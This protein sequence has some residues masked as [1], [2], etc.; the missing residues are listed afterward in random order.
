MKNHLFSSLLFSLILFVHSASYAQQQLEIDVNQTGIISADIETILDNVVV[1]VRNL[2]PGPV[3]A[4]FVA[5]L[6]GTDVQG[7]SIRVDNFLTDLQEVV[8]TPGG[9]LFTI[10]RLIEDY[11]NSSLEEYNIAPAMLRDELSQTRRLPEGSYQL[12]V[13]ALSYPFGELISEPLLQSC[14]QFE[15]QYLDPPY[16]TSPD[17][18]SLVVDNPLDE[19]IVFWTMPQARMGTTYL[20][21]MVRFETRE[22]AEIFESQGR[23]DDIFDALPKILEQDG[24]NAFSFSTVQS[25]SPFD[26][27]IRDIIAVRVTAINPESFIRQ[28]GRSRIVMFHY[29]VSESSVCR[30]PNVTG[31]FVF[32]S[33]KRY[34]S[35]RKIVRSDQ[36]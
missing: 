27:N 13:E 9:D 30:A 19:I 12:C 26:L 5:S 23:P 14:I 31:E 33:A 11:Q 22:L 36:N 34:P 25:D 6:A 28:E 20:L 3:S 2:T 17:H 7:R 35:V 29:G 18:N 4:H 21:E 15:I 16:I 10:R 32:P 8:I 1:R 24:I